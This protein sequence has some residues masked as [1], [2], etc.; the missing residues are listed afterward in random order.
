MFD[1][2]L[3]NNKIKQ[4]HF[5]GIGGIGMSS[6]AT[7]MKTLGWS[8]TGSDLSE[9]NQNIHK[10]IK[11]GVK[12]YPNHLAE[13]IRKDQCIVYSSA[14]KDAN[15]EMI[16]AKK[17]NLRILKR[18]QV[19]AGLMNMK[20]GIAVAGTHGKTTTTSILATIMSESKMSPGYSIGGIVKNL[21]GHAAIG[22]GKHFVAEVDES[23]GS[24]L[25]F[26][27]EFA[28]ITNIDTDHLD[29]Y[30]NEENLYQAFLNFCNNIKDSG[31]LT[32]NGHD[33][34]LA[35]IAKIIDVKTMSVGIGSGFDFSA[36]KIN[37]SRKFST[38][39]LYFENEF[40][41][42]IQIQLV[43]EHNILNSLGAISMAY[44]S[45]VSFDNISKSICKFV[46]VKRRI[47]LLFE[48]KDFEVID[49][50]AHHPTEILVTLQTLKNVNPDK[51]LICIFQPHRFS[52]TK[53]CWDDYLDCFDNSDQLY[54]APIFAA[55]E[56]S[57]QGVTSEN[58]AKDIF[59]LKKIENVS[60]LK[61]LSAIEGIIEENRGSSTLIVTMGAGSISSAVREWT[62][63]Q[64]N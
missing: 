43:G 6:I 1:A 41:A 38:Y 49:D 56:E 19:L 32:I 64:K 54:L 46:N 45:G 27:P 11:L 18:A 63:I 24:F 57:I 16:M 51:K 21:G 39:D 61:S 23:D 62:D 30:G 60:A 53:E 50:Y 8:V 33:K 22:E 58:L 52:R 37:Y 12:V 29:F 13:N 48:E 10:L 14:I 36:K 44:L 3:S 34:E 5:I 15:P 28:T 7:L 2:L 40:V 9:N 35:K 31:C 42:M 55:S 59:D 4:I 25:E 47:E 26:R 17:L 20:S